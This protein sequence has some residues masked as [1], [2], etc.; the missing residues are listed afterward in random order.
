MQMTLLDGEDM[1]AGD[2]RR[3]SFK[4]LSDHQMVMID[5]ALGMIGEFG[6][7]RLVVHKGKLR[8]IE[9]VTS[10]DALRWVFEDSEKS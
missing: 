10:H 5:Q 2:G 1:V 6:E 4:N 8:F 9:T 3:K 7:V